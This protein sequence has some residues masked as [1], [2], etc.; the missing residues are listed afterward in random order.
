MVAPYAMASSILSDLFRLF[1]S[2][3]S[4]SIYWTRG[5][6]HVP[7]TRMISLIYC[8]VLPADS[9][10]WSK[11]FLHL[12]QISRVRSSNLAR[13]IVIEKSSPIASSSHSIVVERACDNWTLAFSHWLRRRL[14][15]RLLPVMSMSF[16]YLN[17]AMQW[18]R[19]M[20]SISCPPRW[21]SPHVAFTVNVLFLIVRI[22]MSSV[23]PP[24]S[25]TK[26]VTSS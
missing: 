24:K 19:S 3:Y 14:S 6:R 16:V 8:L 7:P 13:F 5:I 4:V 18:L 17:S 11:G 9:K 12:S 21:E 10:T 22:E 15:A 2:K 23:P 25:Y 20:L 1:P 26:T